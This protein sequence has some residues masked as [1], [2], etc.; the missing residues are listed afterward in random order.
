MKELIDALKNQGAYSILDDIIKQ[1]YA[2]RIKCT[3][4]AKTIP[5][6]LEHGIVES[7]EATEFML[8]FLHFE[9]EQS[10]QNYIENTYFLEL[11]DKGK[12]VYHLLKRQKE[13]RKEEQERAYKTRKAEQ[14]RVAQALLNVVGIDLED[15]T[16]CED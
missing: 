6:L 8:R 3:E 12:L 11:T 9:S 5:V 13:I 1:G 7:V 2:K 10:K 4:R 16:D 14:K 15:V